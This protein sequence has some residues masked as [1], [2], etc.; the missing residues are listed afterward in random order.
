MASQSSSSAATFR[1][2]DIH[3]DGDDALTCRSFVLGA[4]LCQVCHF[5]QACIRVLYE[6]PF[7]L[8]SFW[9]VWLE[10]LPQSTKIKGT[11]FQFPA[12]ILGFISPGAFK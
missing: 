4:A 2:S 3:D 11:S 6:S 10:C 8:F 1:A 9:A 5:Y 12:P 7:R